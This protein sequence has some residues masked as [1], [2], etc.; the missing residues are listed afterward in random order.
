MFDGEQPRFHTIRLSNR[1]RKSF[2]TRSKRG[3]INHKRMWC[4]RHLPFMFY[5]WYG[6]RRFAAFSLFLFP[7]AVCLHGCN[8][9]YVRMVDI[10]LYWVFVVNDFVLWHSL[11]I[12]LWL[13]RTNTTEYGYHALI[14]IVIIQ[15]ARTW[16][17]QRTVCE[18][19]HRRGF[20]VCVFLLSFSLRETLKHFTTFIW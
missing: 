11:N 13:K 12:I 17:N 8:R 2:E 1:K 5:A 15:N 14:D 3:K 10:A 18:K 7:P 19:H 16:T 4:A 20:F 9:V 6:C